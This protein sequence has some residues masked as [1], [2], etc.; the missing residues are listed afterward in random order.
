VPNVAFAL[1]LI[2]GGYIGLVL[3]DAE[4]GLSPDRAA[5]GR[6]LFWLGMWPAAYGMRLAVRLAS[7]APGVGLARRVVGFVCNGILGYCLFAAALTIAYEALARTG[8]LAFSALWWNVPLA[9]LA[10]CIFLPIWPTFRVAIGIIGA[11]LVD[12]ARQA[13][14]GKG[15]SAAFGGLLAD[16]RAHYRRG[17]ILLGSSFY[18]PSWRVG[19]KDDRGIL[20]IASSRSGK[21]RSAIIP[22]LLLWPGSALVIDPKGTNAAVTAARRGHG[23]GRVTRFLGQQVHIVDPFE[24]V[25][26]ARRSAFNP[27]AAIDLNSD[28]VTEDIGLVADA[29]VVPGAGADTHWDEAAR[30]ILSGVI[31]HLLASGG[32]STLVDV[33]RALAQDAEALDEMFG[34]MMTDRSAGGL[35]ATAA[36]LVMNAGTNERGSFFTTVMRNIRWLD[37][38]A[39]QKTLAKSDFTIGD[40]KKTPMTVYVVLPPDLLEEHSRF[41]RLFVNLAVRG[42][43]Q[44]GK[45]R[46]PVLFLLDEFFSLGTMSV[47]ERAA[48]LLAGYGLKLWPIVQNLTQLQ[49]LYPR[50][51]ET[52][53]R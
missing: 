17:A 52:F 13:A 24:I 6:W 9:A 25:P 32:G 22:N 14:I 51:W 1:V 29:L 31:A 7:D 43:T 12:L 50:N 20:T 26:D 37:S 10:L 45:G 33:R 4:S 42:L 2:A 16:W 44:D 5:A 21:G 15:G 11:P 39:M 35:P 28:R 23:G 38:V 30:T 3:G 27:L 46:M 18:D 40:L 48:G 41:M 8:L 49:H 47:L 53:F 19:H 34:A 36:A